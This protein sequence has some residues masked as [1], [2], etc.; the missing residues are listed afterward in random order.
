MKA[1]P[2]LLD[3]VSES[4][5]FKVR[6]AS[7]GLFHVILTLILTSHKSFF[8]VSFIQPFLISLPTLKKKFNT[9][10][11]HFYANFA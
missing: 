9:D 1:L 7:S 3:N 2:I 4:T 6:E 5:A 8:N 10:A 11:H